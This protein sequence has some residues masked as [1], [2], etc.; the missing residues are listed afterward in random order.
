MA[1]TL[2]QAQARL[3]LIQTAY[4]AALSGR[5]VS[6]Q[7]KSVSYQDIDRLSVE[8]DKWQGIVDTLTAQAAGAKNPGVKIAKWS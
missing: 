6:Y 8:L 4:D 5:T 3:T 7:D 2:A 1:W